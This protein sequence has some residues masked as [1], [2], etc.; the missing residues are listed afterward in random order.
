MKILNFGSLNLDYVYRVD[1]FTAPGKQAPE[2]GPE[3]EGKAAG[4]T[5]Q[6]FPA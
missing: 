1:H 5:R 2:G 6:P 3:G 4:K